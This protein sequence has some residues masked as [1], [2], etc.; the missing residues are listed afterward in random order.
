MIKTICLA[1][2]TILMA[3]AFGLA[4]GAAPTRTPSPPTPDQQQKL[5]AGVDLHDQKQY[6]EA[7]AKYREVLEEN[8]DNMEA[9]Y[10]LAY[11]LLEKKE[12]AQS[13][14]AA[15]RG[16][17][18]RSEMLPMFYDMIA[19]NFEVQKQLPKAVDTYRQGIAVEPAAG[20][21]Y[22]NL[23]V[24]YR[25]GLKDA[26][27]ARET[28]KQGA[29]AAPRYPGI[30]LLLGQWFEAEGY[31][32]QA[33]LALSRALVLDPSVNTYALWRRVLKGPENPMAAGVMQ[34]PDMRRTAAQSM[35]AQPVKTDEGNFAP[36]DGRFA[37]SF[38]ALLESLDD[39]TPE[40]EA[41]VVQ[42]TGILDAIEARPSNGRKP[43]FVDLHY[44]PFFTAMKQKGL[45]E[46]FVYWSC[47][48][49][50]VQGV[51]EWLKANEARVR[52]FRLWAAQYTFPAAAGPA[53]RR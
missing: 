29:A 30:P 32:T 11:S 12:Y 7:I 39:G 21:L 10:E 44:V 31:R 23:A 47:Q 43:S 36:V 22:Y 19:T 34:D 17:Q 40:I 1:L 6:D 28:L 9:L 45:V 18:Y 3:A 33:F 2:G 46:V 41:L 42:V 14:E 25:E 26:R 15:R 16:T 13:V 20:L 51:R 48:R 35:R 52:E 50:P 27:N 4:Q 38:A 5:R 8:A 49:A 37:L 53:A 24:T